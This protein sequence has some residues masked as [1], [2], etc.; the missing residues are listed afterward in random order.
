MDARWRQIRVELVTPTWWV[1]G[2]VTGPEVA[3]V[4][5]AE[6]TGTEHAERAAGFIA[7]SPGFLI[8]VARSLGLE[9]NAE[10]DVRLVQLGG[11]SLSPLTT[12][13]RWRRA[14]TSVHET[15]TE[16]LPV[17]QYEV[18]DLSTGEVESVHLAGD[19]VLAAPGI[20]LT[21]L[22]SPPNLLG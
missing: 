7:D 15:G 13:W 8:A 12:L 16:P 11:P 2:G 22:E 6:E 17:S 4:R 14:G 21:D 19:V 5:A 18:T 3:W 20:E 9:E 10:A 1:R